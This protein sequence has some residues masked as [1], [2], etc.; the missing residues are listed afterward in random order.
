MFEYVKVRRP[1]A[2][3]GVRIPRPDGGRTTPGRD[4]QS[5]DVT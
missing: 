2:F 5:Y 3:E 1:Y 4:C